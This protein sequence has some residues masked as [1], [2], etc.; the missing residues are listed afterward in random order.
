MGPLTSAGV[1]SSTGMLL[2]SPSPP[3]ARPFYVLFSYTFS[4]RLPYF[5]V[6]PSLGLSFHPHV[7]F[8]L[9]VPSLLVPPRTFQ[10]AFPS[11][12]PSSPGTPSDSLWPL[13]SL[14]RTRVTLTFSPHPSSNL[15]PGRPTS[16]PRGEGNERPGPPPISPLTSRATPR[17]SRFFLVML[18]AGIPQSLLD[19]PTGGNTHE[20]KSC[21]FLI[22]RGGGGGRGAAGGHH[23]IEGRGQLGA[24]MFMRGNL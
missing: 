24:A 9:E 17:F 16:P 21:F 11:A 6:P 2:G 5:R 18:L 1:P 12:R 10:L 15:E 22:G 3:S 23:L 19:A 8:P 20:Q 14:A 7:S 13:T 4:L